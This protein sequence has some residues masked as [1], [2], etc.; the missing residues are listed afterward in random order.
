MTLEGR[1][2]S[3]HRMGPAWRLPLFERDGGD[4]AGL[5]LTRGDCMCSVVSDIL[6]FL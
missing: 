1:W 2:H 6:T 3:A 4:Y 5:A